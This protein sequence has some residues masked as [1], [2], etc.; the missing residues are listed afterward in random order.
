[1]FVQMKEVNMSTNCGG[2]DPKAT[3]NKC[4][5]KV[6]FEEIYLKLGTCNKCTNEYFTLLEESQFPG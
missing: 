3:C 4:G 2:N 6:T 1:M 5:R